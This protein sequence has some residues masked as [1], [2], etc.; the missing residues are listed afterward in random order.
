MRK[1]NKN[2][3]AGVNSRFASVSELEI[4]K[5]QEDA[6][7]ENTRKATKF[8]VKVFRDKRNIII[9]GDFN[10]SFTHLDKAGGKP[11]EN[12]KCVIDKISNLINLYSTHDV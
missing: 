6:V 9:G 11:V 2:K 10:R 1:P 3:M 4:L 5:M 8:G 12:K 7:P